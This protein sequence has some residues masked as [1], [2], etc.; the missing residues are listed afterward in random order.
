MLII[1][2]GSHVEGGTVEQA[3][4]NAQPFLDGIHKMGMG[5]VS[6]DPD[7]VYDDGRWTFVFRHPATGKTVLL[8]THGLTD[9]ECWKRLFIPRIYWD[10]SST[11]EPQITDFLPDGW[12]YRVVFEPLKPT[13]N[14]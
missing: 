1:N 14:D 12:T 8:Q 3:R 13:D 7:P 6:I 11:A 10:G 9:E 2:P 4:I 5:E